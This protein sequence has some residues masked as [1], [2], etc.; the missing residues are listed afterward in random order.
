MIMGARTCPTC[1]IPFKDHRRCWRCGS[2]GGRGHA[3][4]PIVFGLCAFCREELYDAESD[5]EWRERPIRRAGASA[6]THYLTTREAAKK[7]GVEVH[8]KSWRELGKHPH[9]KNPH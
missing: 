7:Y 3:A 8:E 9:T 6:S 2:T 5:D 1:G 4:G